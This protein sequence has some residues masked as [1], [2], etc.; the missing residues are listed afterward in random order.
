MSLPAVISADTR[1]AEI[2]PQLHVCRRR[3]KSRCAMDL[4]AKKA[5]D[6]LR[7]LFE[8]NPSTSFIGPQVNDVM[9]EYDSDIHKSA[10]A[11]GSERSE[12]RDAGPGTKYAERSH[13]K[14][15]VSIC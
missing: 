15:T 8:R 11:S 5:A 7:Q 4:P 14:R 9:S 6:T 12:T 13:S 2:I 3:Q 1:T 10:G